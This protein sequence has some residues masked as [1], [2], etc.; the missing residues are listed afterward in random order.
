MFVGNR[1]GRARADIETEGRRDG[2]RSRGVSNCL[3]LDQN[4][5]HCSI[6]AVDILIKLRRVSIFA[7]AYINQAVFQEHHLPEAVPETFHLRLAL[8]KPNSVQAQVI[9]KC[10]RCWLVCTARRQSVYL[11]QYGSVAQ[12]G[13]GCCPT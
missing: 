3:L 6:R 9:D 4:C 8:Q 10:R 11:K 2:W 5:C 7:C 1:R 12:A 13:K